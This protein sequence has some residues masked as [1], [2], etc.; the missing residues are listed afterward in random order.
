[1]PSF[2]LPAFDA[3]P[4]CDTV[5]F[6]LRF[7][8][9]FAA[10]DSTGSLQAFSLWFLVP[11]RRA[12]FLTHPRA[13]PKIVSGCF[14]VFQFTGFAVLSLCRRL[15]RRRLRLCVCGSSVALR[16]SSSQAAVGISF[17]VFS[18]EEAQAGAS[19]L[20]ESKSGVHFCSLF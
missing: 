12:R 11:R 13:H 19:G 9:G 14:T 7:F 17:A 3:G 8:R 15:M 10:P 16:F 20:D 4:P 1:M 5:V 2:P 6:C 18:S